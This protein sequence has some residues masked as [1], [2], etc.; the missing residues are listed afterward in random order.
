MSGTA[1]PVLGVIEGRE[2][3]QRRCVVVVYVLRRGG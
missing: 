2:F 1:K 3:S